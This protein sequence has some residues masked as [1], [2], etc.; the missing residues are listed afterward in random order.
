M[1]LYEHSAYRLSPT[2]RAT[3]PVPAQLALGWAAY[4][5]LSGEA[6]RRPTGAKSWFKWLFSGLSTWKDT[7]VS[8]A[9]LWKLLSCLY[10]FNFTCMNVCL[11]ICMYTTNI[12]VPWGGQ[13][14]AME[15]ELELCG[16]KLLKIH[17]KNW[18]QDKFKEQQTLLTE[19]SILIGLKKYLFF[20]FWIRYMCVCLST[21][22]VYV[23][24][25]ECVRTYMNVCALPHE[26]MYVCTCAG[27]Q[28]REMSGPLEEQWLFSTAELLLQPFLLFW[29]VWWQVAV[30]SEDLGAGVGLWGYFSSC[31]GVLR[32]VL[33]LKRDDPEL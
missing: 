22:I 24:A 17:F 10:F 32:T 18:T 11:H 26:S 2:L 9:L 21:C 19:E 28:R 3:L 7:H 14:R 27:G 31:L 8:L 6:L 4:V 16:F 13:Q 20:L 1:H 23:C 30:K 25:L 12:L 33:S 15:M 29:A 5:L